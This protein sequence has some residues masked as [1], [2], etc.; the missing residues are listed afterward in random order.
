VEKGT[1][2]EYV[3]V[4]REDKNIRRG[5]SEKM[6]KGADLEWEDQ[7]RKELERKKKEKE[8]TVLS[9]VRTYSVSFSLLLIAAGI[10]VALLSF[11]SSCVACIL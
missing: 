1:P 10:T 9:A 2:G 6:Y 3:P 7:M 8:G 4:V 11:F 5:K